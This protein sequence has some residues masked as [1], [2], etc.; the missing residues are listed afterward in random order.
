MHD[1]EIIESDYGTG[2]KHLTIYIIG[3]II[4]TLLTLSSFWITEAVNIKRIDKFFILYG[5]AFIQFITQLI[6]FIR[7]NTKTK[8]SK[9]NVIS[10][11]F[12]CMILITI[13]AGTLWIM[14]NLNY[15]MIH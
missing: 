2:K 3:F 14:W 13:V 11:V 1:P 7:L 15:N 10:L 9:L 6:C 4:C 12:T 5:A 8:Q